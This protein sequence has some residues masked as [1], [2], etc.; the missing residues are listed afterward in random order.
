MSA[1]TTRRGLL[2][3]AGLAAAGGATAAFAVSSSPPK[4][5]SDDDAKLVELAREFVEKGFEQDRLEASAV[6]TLSPQWEVLDD[7]ADSLANRLGTIASEAIPLRASSPEGRKAKA[8]LLRQCLPF[9]RR[10]LDQPDKWHDAEWR[11][12]GREHVLAWS[13]V[14][15]MIEGLAP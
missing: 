1:R 9:L 10:A 6:A 7:Q 11:I 2:A 14:R 8:V 13:L 3:G 4:K 15:D 12:T 5:L